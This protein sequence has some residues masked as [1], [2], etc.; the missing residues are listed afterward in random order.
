MIWAGFYLRAEIDALAAPGLLEIEERG[1][2][3]HG[4]MTKAHILEEIRRTS[5]AN[6]GRAIG[7]LRFEAETGIRM[8]DWRKLWARWGDAVREAG[9]APMEF[10]AAYGDV[11]LLD[12]YA[13]LIR[14]MGQLPAWSDLNLRANSDPSFPSEKVFRRFKSKEEMVKRVKEHCR[15]AGGW[16]DVVALCEGYTPRGSRNPQG[17]V[18][19]EEVEI[20]FVYLIKSGRFF[21]VGKTNSAG[22]RERELAIQLPEKAAT[23][24]VIRTDDPSGIEAYWHNRFAAMRKNGEW[25]RTGR[26]GRKG[27][28]VAVNSCR[29]YPSQ[30]R[31][32]LVANR[33]TP[34]VEMTGISVVLEIMP[35]MLPYAMA[36]RACSAASCSCDSA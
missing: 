7:R 11:T 25:F 9:F 30:P 21:K 12:C 16:D 2:D 3:N 34:A 5:A 35:A 36:V 4:M 27:V 1:D 8:S 20:G 14:E 15:E 32:T 13:K 28:Q 23:V 18:I 22:R 33:S 10:V 31:V 17:E 29:H 24:H 6:D 19:A 26:L